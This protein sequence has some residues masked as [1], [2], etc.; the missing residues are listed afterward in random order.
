[1]HLEKGQLLS[2]LD[3]NIFTIISEEGEKL[4][5][6]S[7]V[8]GGFVRDIFLHRPSKDIDVVTVGSGIELA[9]AVSKRLGKGAHL[10]VFKNFGTAQVKF[11][12]LEVEFVGARKESYT[13]DSRKPIVENGTLTDDQDRRDFTINALALSLNKGYFGELVDPFD[14]L[15]DLELKIILSPLDPY[16]TFPDDHSRL[17]PGI[18]FATHLHYTILDD[19]Y[20]PTS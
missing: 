15:K 12:E 13:H 14:G 8:I 1:M 5:V 11:H 19:N 20:K 10:S 3:H 4:N 9:S 16:Y 18:C 6:S 7:Y 17:M 2:H